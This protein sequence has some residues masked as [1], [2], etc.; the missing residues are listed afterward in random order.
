MK[1]PNNIKYKIINK[2]V[3]S[4]ELIIDIQKCINSNKNIDITGHV[5]IISKVIDNIFTIKI[6]NNKVFKLMDRLTSFITKI[7]FFEFTY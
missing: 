4:K 1:L 3:I 5:P 2:Y 6:H 7:L